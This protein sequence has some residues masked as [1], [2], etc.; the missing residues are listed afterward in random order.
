MSEIS[1]KQLRSRG[2]MLQRDGSTYSVRFGTTGGRCS[3]QQLTEL[4]ELCQ[5]F[6]CGE[7]HLTV[8]Q[9]IEIHHVPEAKIEEFIQA[10]EKTTLL[11]ARS[12]ARLRTIVACPGN[13]VCKFAQI[14][15]QAVAEEINTRFGQIESFPAKVKTAIAG[16]RNCCTRADFSDIGIVGTQNG[17]YTLYA[18]G[19]GGRNFMPGT[20]I[21]VC[22]S[23]DEL[24]QAIDELLRKYSSQAQP[25]ERIGAWQAKNGDSFTQCNGIMEKG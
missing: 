14:D 18:G 25:K 3:A 15:S 6:G 22:E 16:C 24:M 13:K 2:I 1:T 21:A 23:L 8:R 12:G 7:I 11:P 17:Q 5:K 19:K 4:A 9:A 20:P 10:C